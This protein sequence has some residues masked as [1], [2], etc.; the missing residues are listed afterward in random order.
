MSFTLAGGAI[1]YSMADAVK[2]VCS[3]AFDT[4]TIR[5][6]RRYPHAFGTHEIPRYAYRTYDCVAASPG[7]EL[8]GRRGVGTDKMP[9]PDAS[10]S[11]SGSIG[12]HLRPGKHDL[13]V[14]DWQ[15]YLDFADRH[16]K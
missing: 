10:P 5:P 8:L 4:E 3:Y 6:T 13:T 15:R 9:V 1:T 14:C 16:M 11:Q 7:Y 2:T 12:Y